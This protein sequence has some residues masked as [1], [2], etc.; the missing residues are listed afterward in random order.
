MRQS[1]LVWYGG[2]CQICGRTWPERDGSPFFAAARLVE[3]RHARWLDDP[4]NA[5]CLCADHFAQWCHAAKLAPLDIAEQLKALSL[6]SLGGKDRLSILF[7]MLGEDVEVTYCEKHMMA[8]KKL[9]DVS[10]EDDCE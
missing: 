2:Q 10:E 5:I 4:A 3:R 7:T 8:L 6:P 1:L 9:L